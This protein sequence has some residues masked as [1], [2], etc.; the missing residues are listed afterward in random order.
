MNNRKSK[1]VTVQL[2]RLLVSFILLSV[3]IC[4]SFSFLLRQSIQR[5]TDQSIHAM[6][7]LKQGFEILDAVYQEQSVK[8]RLLRLKDP[9]DVK[10]TLKEMKDHQ[11]LVRTKLM[12]SGKEAEPVLA[13]HEQM[14]AIDKAIVGKI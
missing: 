4:G 6:N 8:N 13:K 3:G 11:K 14:A 10:K 1:F 9:D 2:A 5:A 7:Q 12:A